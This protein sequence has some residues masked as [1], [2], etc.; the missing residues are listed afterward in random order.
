MK[1]YLLVYSESA[2]PRETMR[3]AIV[4][5]GMVKGWRYDMPNSFYL[6]SAYS[7]EEIARK[8]R[9]ARP[10]GRFIIT[11]LHPNR[12]GWLPPDSWKF[13]KRTE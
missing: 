6:F 3:A 1:V 8:L 7:A 11:E 9:E 12:F 13:F 2:G 10:I 4:G 5:T